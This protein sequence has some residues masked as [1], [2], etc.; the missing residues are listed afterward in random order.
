MLR[1]RGLD[2]GTFIR[3]A[4]AGRRRVPRPTH[5]FVCVA[6]HF[7]P[8]VSGAPLAKQRER[9][10]RWVRDY[11]PTVE[12]FRDTRGRVPQ[13]TFFF[14]MERYRPELIDSLALLV[15][16]HYGDIEVHLHHADDHPERL[17][18]FLLAAADV[19]H[20]RHGLLSVDPA[21]R[22]RYGFIHGNWALDN[23]HPQGRWCGVNNELTVLRETGCYADF[24]M[25]AAPS[26]EQTRTI[27]SIYY[28][29]DDPQRP[30]SHDT[31]IAAAVGLAPVPDGLLLIQGPLLITQRHLWTRPRVENGAL[32][33]S[34]PPTAQRLAD[35][36]RAGVS[37]RGR[38]DWLFVKLH[39]H[40][41]RE[42]NAAVLLGPPMQ[43]LH[44]ALRDLSAALGFDY[45]YV[46]AREMA[47]LVRQA[48]Q[49][50]ATPDFALLSGH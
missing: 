44:G 50:G 6:D 8:D 7:E 4:L 12:P 3:A 11:G 48:E 2:P 19:L 37:V 42:D 46:T 18:E 41:A 22:I 14:P 32:A 34:Q 24:T 16:Q 31:G 38:E 40:G 1:L 33:A 49:G 10:A 28:A 20:R 5:V 43:Q 30:K 29:V 35:W 23:S 17:R 45:F 25:P 39:T 13:H 47:Q 26:P 15:R 36:L 21:G 27:N 9:V